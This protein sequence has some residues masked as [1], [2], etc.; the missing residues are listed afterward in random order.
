MTNKKT[1]VTLEDVADATGFSRALIS[2]V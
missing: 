1:P 2:I